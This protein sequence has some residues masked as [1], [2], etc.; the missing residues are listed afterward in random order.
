MTNPRDPFKVQCLSRKPFTLERERFFAKDCHCEECN[1]EAISN[2]GNWE[3][4]TGLRPRNDR[5][6]L[7]SIREVP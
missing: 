6:R 4:A 7:F 1:D 2:G 3:L 5:F